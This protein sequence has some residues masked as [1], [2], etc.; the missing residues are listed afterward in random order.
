MGTECMGDMLDMDGV[1]C[2]CTASTVIKKE[3]LKER[4]RKQ[5]K[6]DSLRQNT[7]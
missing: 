2:G 7:Y 4:K 3:T 6:S 5:A 1:V